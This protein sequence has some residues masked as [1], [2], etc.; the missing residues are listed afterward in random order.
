[1]HSKDGMFDKVG[2]KRLH[3]SCS[4]EL[5]PNVTKDEKRIKT[6]VELTYMDASMEEATVPA[7][8]N[9]H[10]KQELSGVWKLT[11]SGCTH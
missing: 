10:Y 7:E 5:E 6:G 9:D 4:V 1:M 3:E 11:S 8:H 2:D